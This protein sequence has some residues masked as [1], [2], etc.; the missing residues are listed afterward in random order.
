M[1][2]EAWFGIRWRNAVV[3]YGPKKWDS[4]LMLIL[5]VLSHHMDNK[6]GETWVSMETIA[7]EARLTRPTVSRKL[8]AAYAALGLGDWLHRQ[9]RSTD[10]GYTS[11]VYRGVI[12]SWVEAIPRARQAHR[13]SQPRAFQAKPSAPGTHDHVLEEHTNYLSNYLELEDAYAKDEHGVPRWVAGL[14]QDMTAA[15]K[16]W[17]VEEAGLDRIPPEAVGPA[18]L[19]DTLTRRRELAERLAAQIWERKSRSD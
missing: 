17:F 11:Y 5:H 9:K 12:P 3:S 18:L 16:A 14:F 10:K 13:S 19:Q 6:T 15:D 1:S 7:K 2:P 8:K 4:T